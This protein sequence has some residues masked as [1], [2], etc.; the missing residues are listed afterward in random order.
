MSEQKTWK[1]CVSRTS[2]KSDTTKVARR[3][4]ANYDKHRESFSSTEEMAEA[5]AK[6][7][8]YAIFTERDYAYALEKT[9]LA[10]RYI[11]DSVKKATGWTIW[12][13]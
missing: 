3:E 11:E 7:L 5:Y 12:Q 1:Y 9:Q 13:I 10:K 4:I 6:A 2:S 8:T